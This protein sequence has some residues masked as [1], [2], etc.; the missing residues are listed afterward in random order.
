MGLEGPL[1]GELPPERVRSARSL[2]R[3]KRASVTRDARPA[4]EV[5]GGP[6]SLENDVEGFSSAA[7]SVGLDGE[8]GHGG[9]GDGVMGGCAGGG[10]DGSS[11]GCSSLVLVQLLLTLR[12]SAPSVART[13][14]WRMGARTLAGSTSSFRGAVGV[15]AEAGG[16]LGFGAGSAMGVEEAAAG[17]SIGGSA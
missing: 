12:P 17:G 13:A 8:T 11:G 5:G 1:G 7:C 14:E 6:S 3:C 10:V 16:G 2:A 4:A 9:D 15:D